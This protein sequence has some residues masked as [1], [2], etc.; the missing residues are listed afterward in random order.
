M[1]AMDLLGEIANAI[2]WLVVVWNL[3][4]IVIG[5]PILLWQGRRR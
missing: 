2:Y 1:L 3:G 5:L 4:A